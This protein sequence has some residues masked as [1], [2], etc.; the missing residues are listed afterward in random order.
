M[1]IKTI[2]VIDDE[3]DICSFLKNVLEESGYRAF[4]AYD[5]I[6][7]LESIEQHN[8]NLIILDMNMPKMSGIEFYARLASVNQG[9]PQTPIIILSGHGEMKPIFENL[10]VAAFVTKPIV[11]SD[12]L[13]VV[14]RALS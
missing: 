4:V 6:E 5:G 1:P 9:V 14:Q 7:G 2:L 3:K 11:I 10:H 8:P 12:F 13:E